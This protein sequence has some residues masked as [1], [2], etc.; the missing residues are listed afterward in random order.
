LPQ[1]TTFT[2]V[3]KIH[4]LTFGFILLH[5]VATVWVWRL[6]STGNLIKAKTIDK[7]AFWISLTTYVLLNVFFIFQ[8]L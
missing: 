1:T 2:L 5:L 3:D 6:H 7:R 4:A 8:V